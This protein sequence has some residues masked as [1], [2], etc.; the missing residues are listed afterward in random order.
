MD[1]HSTVSSSVV[2]VYQDN[3]PLAHS[4]VEK[5]VVESMIV[6]FAFVVE[7]IAPPTVEQEVATPTIEQSNL[8]PS[9]VQPP[10]LIIE[11]SIV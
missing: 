4:T 1:P 9:T 7:K 8:D 3:A 5:K 10:T 11:P 2:V 6:L